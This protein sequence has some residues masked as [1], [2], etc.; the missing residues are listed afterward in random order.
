MPRSRRFFRTLF[1]LLLIGAC[2]AAALAPLLAPAR[3]ASYDVP[4]LPS[5]PVVISSFRFTGPGGEDDEYIELYNNTGSPQD[6]TGWTVKS[7]FGSTVGGSVYAFA[8][9]FSLA[10]HQ[11][12]LLGGPKYTGAADACYSSGV[13]SSQGGIALFNGSNLT[14]A[15][16]QVGLSID[17]YIEGS[18]ALSPISGNNSYARTITNGVYADTN[19]NTADFTSQTS[20][21]HNSGGTTS[22]CYTAPATATASPTSA[23]A[24]AT[25]VPTYGTVV[26]NEIGW[27]GT[28]ASVFGSSGLTDQWIELYNPQSY[29]IDI[30]GWTLSGNIGTI[31]SSN[32]YNG[33]LT[34]TKANSPDGKTEP[35]IPAHGFF[36]IAQNS[37]EFQNLTADY[38]DANLH[39]PYCYSPIY[40]G[41]ELKLNAAPDAP[42]YSR[43]IDTAD[44]SYPYYWAAGNLSGHRSM[45]RGGPSGPLPD[46]VTSWIT[47]YGPAPACPAHPNVRDRNGNVIN[48]TPGCPN[49]ASI[50]TPTPLPT[51]THYKTPTGPPPTPFGHMVINEF[52]PRAGYDWNQDGTVDVYDT[53]VELKNLGPVAAQLSGWKI[54]V[55]SPGGPSSYY[56]PSQTLQPGQRMV[57][58]RKT[59]GLALYNVGGTVRLINNRGIIVDARSYG[60]AVAPDQST[61]RIPDG[62]Y[63]RFPC[64]PTPGNENS[65]TG[66][67]PVP[68]PVIAS[69][70][71]PCLMADTVPDPF[72]QAECYGYGGDIFNPAYWNDQAGFNDFPVP[73]QINKSGVVVK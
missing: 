37:T 4:S 31:G 23:P 20:A 41:E 66:S 67:L 11:Y 29:N 47:Y 18:T 68:P 61:C 55:I 34:F 15:V 33:V 32:G 2:F 36:V 57:Y 52:L 59:S 48:G 63:W 26:I 30:G 50:V 69:Q 43:L 10:S 46:I 64:F 39:L 71:P 27:A 38:I 24:T 16:D 7:S 28:S 51:A 45:E 6:M 58:Y 8:N 72:K 53:F 13:D 3:A 54:D 9:N 25:P 22:V 49:W 12:F 35:I 56:L 5:A 21:P 42:M 17:G 40:C 19:V 14:T 70:P 62:Y 44:Q 65:L 73:D 1:A 60:P